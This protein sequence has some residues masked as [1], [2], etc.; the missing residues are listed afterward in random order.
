[1]PLDFIPFLSIAVSAYFR[2]FTYAQQLLTPFFAQKRMTPQQVHLFLT[3]RMG[4]IK[5][6]GFACALLERIPIIG[7]V[8]SISNR[9][10]AAMLAH[11]LEKRQ[12]KFAAGELR[13]LP[14]DQ[15]ETLNIK[16]LASILKSSDGDDFAPQAEDGFDMPGAVLSSEKTGGTGGFPSVASAAP[17]EGLKHRPV[18]AV[19]AA[20]PAPGPN[21]PPPAYTEHDMAEAIGMDS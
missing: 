3:E 5:S 19:P 6:Y 21:E 2:A 17:A 1:M 14:K 11:D 13:R 7:I 4:S 9:V 18:P 8:F 15:T 16:S 12:H 20:A 10:G